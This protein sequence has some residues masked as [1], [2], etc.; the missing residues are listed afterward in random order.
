[1][2]PGAISEIHIAGVQVAIRYANLPEETAAR[3]VPDTVYLNLDEKIYR[4]G[5]KEY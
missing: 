2:P 1:M 5:D 4:T 3:F